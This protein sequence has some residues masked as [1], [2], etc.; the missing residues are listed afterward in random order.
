MIF[1]KTVTNMGEH[2]V[3]RID[4]A[5]VDN[6]WRDVSSHLFALF[7]EE[8]CHV[9]RYSGLSCSRYTVE[10]HIGWNL[11]IQSLDKIER[12]TLN[13]LLSV[14]HDCWSMAV[15]KD[16]FVCEQTLSGEQCIEDVFLQILTSIKYPNFGRLSPRIGIVCLSP[17]PPHK[18]VR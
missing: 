9:K 1:K 12:N 13:F 15:V 6:D 11:S 8:I 10:N 18:D 4:L 5:T 2:S 3:L 17:S 14:R 16:F 7:F